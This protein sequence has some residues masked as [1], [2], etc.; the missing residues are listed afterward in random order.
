MKIILNIW[1]KPF[2]KFKDFTPTTNNPL[3]CPIEVKI[4]FPCIAFLTSAF[5][6]LHSGCDVTTYVLDYHYTIDILPALYLLRM[7]S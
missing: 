2:F 7:L 1:I 5:M 6:L 3:I 4:I